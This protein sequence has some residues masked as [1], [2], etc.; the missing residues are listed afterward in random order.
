M[1]K[2]I[3]SLAQ[4]DRLQACSLI[5]AAVSQ[6]SDEAHITTGKEFSAA[7]QGESRYRLTK[8]GL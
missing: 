1:D 4:L 6:D 7:L 2:R 3:C 8:T 5:P